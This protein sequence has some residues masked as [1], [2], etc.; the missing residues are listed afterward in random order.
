MIVGQEKLYR[1]ITFLPYIFMNIPTILM[2]IEHFHI[3]FLDCVLVACLVLRKA[4][5]N[6]AAMIN[7]QNMSQSFVKHIPTS[8]FC[9]LV[10]GWYPLAKLCNYGTHGKSPC[11]MGKLSISMA[12]SNGCD[13]LPEGTRLK[14]MTKN[15]VTWDHPLWDGW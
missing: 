8:S 12:M 9:S 2:I 13:S 5:H 6:M 3:S 1:F 4:I 14:S 11:W 10:T 15:I 7:F